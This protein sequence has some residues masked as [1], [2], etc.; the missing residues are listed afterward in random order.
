MVSAGK[1]DG[2]VGVVDLGSLE[3]SQWASMPGQ[4]TLKYNPLFKVGLRLRY[5]SHTHL[6][7]VAYQLGML[8]RTGI[9]KYLVTVSIPKCR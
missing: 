1:G 8:H 7:Q 4:Q 6:I 3:G 2:R 9:C 5:I